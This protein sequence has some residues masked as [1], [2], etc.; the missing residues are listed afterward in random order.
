MKNRIVSIIKDLSKDKKRSESPT[1]QK[2]GVVGLSL[3]VLFYDD[4]F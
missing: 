3:N 4:F 2:W 1:T